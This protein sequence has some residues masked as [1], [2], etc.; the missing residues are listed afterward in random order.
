MDV[1]LAQLTILTVALLVVPSSGVGLDLTSSERLGLLYSSQ[2]QFSV[3][4]DPLIKI[5][6][7]EGQQAIRFTPDGPIRVL[8]LGDGGPE[9]SLPGQREFE[10]TLGSGNAGSYRYWVVVGRFLPYERDALVLARESWA[11]VGLEA[12]SFQL[13]SY[14][15]VGGETFDNRETILAIGGMADEANA[16]R[17]AEQVESELAIPAELHAELVDFPSGQLR[18][19]S[20]G[21]EVEITTQ[22]LIWV[23]SQPG[24]TFEVSGD[25]FSTNPEPGDGSPRTYVGSLI[26]TVDKRGTLALVNELPA[27]RLLEGI[28]PVEIYASAPLEALKAQA[29]A[30]RGELL[31][32]LGTRYLADPY[33][34]CADQRCQVYR[35]VG[36]EHARTSQAVADTQGVV[37]LNEGHIARAVYSASCGGSLGDYA[38]TWGG[39][40][41]PYLVAH[42]D[43]FHPPEAFA[44]GLGAENVEHFL[45]SAPATFDNIENYN[46]QRLFR[47]DVTKSQ[48]ELTSD[49]N[50]RYPVGTV[51]A[52]NVQARDDSGRVVRLEIV[53]RDATVVVER[54]L[55][56]RR[57]LGGLR[58]ALF[59]LSAETDSAGELSGVSIRG[60]GFGHGVGLC[61]I[62]SIG[63]A[64]SGLDYTEILS[65]YYSGTRVVSLWD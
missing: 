12:E 10:V 41:V 37:L 7:I 65:H 58:S 18:L 23:T 2:L 21:Y 5:G 50:E 51:T 30:A 24:G 45:N 20:P 64:E 28:L 44:S 15:S 61:Q 49:V 42:M 36:T 11:G 17:L 8:P 3:D 59:V 63:A 47:W 57:A 16:R 13:G 29:V 62:G 40:P 26:F 55:P 32:D 1:R 35:G 34:T 48:A 43:M 6:I 9:I 52:L 31:A 56:I 54:E 39:E 46:A 4:G 60:A 19:S 33:M 27:E 22:D 14:F 25:S 53:G 38:S